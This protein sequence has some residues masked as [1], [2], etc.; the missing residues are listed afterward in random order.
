MGLISNGTTL[1][2]AGATSS[3][4]FSGTMILLSTTTASSSATIDITSGI[5]S[6]YKEY[7]IHFF[8]VHPQSG[9]RLGFQADVG[10][11]TNYAQTITSASSVARHSEDNATAD[12][13]Y[14]TGD[15]QAQGTAL[16]R[17]SCGGTVE[18]DA[19]AS[20]TGILTLYDPANTTF[21]KH[22][23]STMQIYNNDQSSHNSYVAGYINTTTAITR[24]RFKYESGNIDSGTFKLYGIT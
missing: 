1:L 15:D 5:N 4:V 19:D 14:N 13:G 18:T 7:Q 10:T 2:D 16:Q 8:D 3:G 9:S 23:M 11:A 17:L 24:V 22:F 6:T 12:V 20:A 21:L